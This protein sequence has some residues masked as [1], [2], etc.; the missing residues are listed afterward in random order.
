MRILII[1]WS[2][3]MLT[4]S[5]FAQDKTQDIIAKL[6]HDLRDQNYLEYKVS[7]RSHIGQVGAE[8]IDINEGVVASY[9]KVNYNKLDD[10]EMLT[11]SDY[12]F[13]IN[14][15]D[16]V[17][18]YL[19]I[20]DING[21]ARIQA[22]DFSIEKVLEMTGATKIV[23]LDNGKKQVQ[24]EDLLNPTIEAITVDFD[25][26]TFRVERMVMYYRTRVSERVGEVVMEGRP[27]MEMLISDYQSGDQPADP[28]LFDKSR[29]LKKAGSKWV[30]SKQYQDYKLQ[31]DTDITQN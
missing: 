18:A 10:V 5:A 13:L 12:R 8:P 21:G 11:G 17:A 15:S 26:K 25:A 31:G 22:G 29:F 30:L 1:V 2:C 20:L 6:N 24:F 28:Q 19:S 7:Y 4:L 27:V 14:H 23:E 3:L 9:K 16:K